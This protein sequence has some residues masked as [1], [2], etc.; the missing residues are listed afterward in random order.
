MRILDLRPAYSLPAHILLRYAGPSRVIMY[1]DDPKT[2][3]FVE[4]DR[5]SDGTWHAG[6]QVLKE[7]MDTF[8]GV[9]LERL[10]YLESQPEGLN[11]EDYLVK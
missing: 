6:T 3:F 9:I 4:I 1:L 11:L 2:F 7:G 8:V 10:C 5:W